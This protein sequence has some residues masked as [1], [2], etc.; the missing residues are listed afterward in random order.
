MEASETGRSEMTKRTKNER[1]NHRDT[2]GEALIGSTLHIRRIHYKNV[3]FSEYLDE[4][5]SKIAQ[6]VSL[7]HSIYEV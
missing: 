1:G 3:E 2:G 4:K 6:K 5:R 7:S